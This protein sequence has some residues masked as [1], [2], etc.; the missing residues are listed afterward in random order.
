MDRRPFNWPPK[1]SEKHNRY[2]NRSRRA[3]YDRCQ[4][5][6][7]WA[8]LRF[9]RRLAVRFKRTAHSFVGRDALPAFS[10]GPHVLRDISRFYLSKLVVEPSNQSSRK[11]THCISPLIS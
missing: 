2:G 4:V 10:T 5:R 11:I 8:L 9:H 1:E 6:H 3:P 7:T